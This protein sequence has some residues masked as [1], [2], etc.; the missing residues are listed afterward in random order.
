MA[1]RIPH[2]NHGNMYTEISVA[3][4]SKIQSIGLAQCNE[5]NSS[6]Q[7]C[8]RPQTHTASIYIF[9]SPSSICFNRA[10]SSMCTTTTVRRKCFT[11]ENFDEFDELKLPHQNFPYQY[12]T[13]Q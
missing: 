5:L 4:H 6:N 10:V 7:I 1:L 11:G 2:I 13:F 9:K 12:F 3:L 8:K